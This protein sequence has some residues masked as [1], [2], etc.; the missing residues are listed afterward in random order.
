MKREQTALTKEKQ[1][2]NKMENLKGDSKTKVVD[3]INNRMDMPKTGDI[4]QKL[5]VRTSP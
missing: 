3:R 4:F 2:T 1:Q 5:S